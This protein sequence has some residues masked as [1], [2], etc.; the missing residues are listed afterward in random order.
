MHCVG[1]DGVPSQEP[2][3]VGREEARRLGLGCNAEGRV[4]MLIT[5][6]PHECGLRGVLNA[7]IGLLHDLE[8][9]DI[10]S[11]PGLSGRL[12]DSLCGLR[13]LKSFKLSDRS[14]VEA[15]PDCITKFFA[16][17]DDDDEDKDDL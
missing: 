13:K 8:F 15:V 10:R 4:T 9:I 1:S 12:P 17:E 6:N 14:Q 16:P 5:D 7:S 2:L 11:S 3:A